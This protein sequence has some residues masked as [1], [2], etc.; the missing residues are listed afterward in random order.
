MMTKAQCLE[1]AA[2]QFVYADKFAK[3]DAGTKRK[4]LQCKAFALVYSDRALSRK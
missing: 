4:G 1:F 2:S 3:G